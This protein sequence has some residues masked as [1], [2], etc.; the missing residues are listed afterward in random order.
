MA[1]RRYVD[2]EWMV[3]IRNLITTYIVKN[4]GGTPNLPG[5]TVEVLM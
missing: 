4:D 5:I 2:Q 1:Y 3:A